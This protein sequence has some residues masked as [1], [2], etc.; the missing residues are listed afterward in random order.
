MARKL[1][2]KEPRTDLMPD[3]PPPGASELKEMWVV[4]GAVHFGLRFRDPQTM[5]PMPIHEE[6]FWFLPVY[7]SEEAARRDFPDCEVQRTMLYTIG[8]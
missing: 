3:Q 2:A 4:I 1:K 8:R 6:P 7:E 5:Q